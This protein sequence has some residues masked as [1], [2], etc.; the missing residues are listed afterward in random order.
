MKNIILTAFLLVAAMTSWQAAA[1]S[2]KPAVT[3]STANTVIY[4]PHDDSDIN[5]RIWVDGQYLGRLKHGAVISLNLS[6]GDHTI[7]LNDAHKTTYQ[8]NV[9][10]KNVS[11]IQASI[12]KKTGVTFSRSELSEKLVAKLSATQEVVSI[13]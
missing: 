11:Y 8:L 10:P 2:A 5:Y 13:N 7:T 1:S 3:N 12:S 9:E 6:E 4:R